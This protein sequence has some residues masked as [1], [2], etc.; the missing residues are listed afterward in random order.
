LLTIERPLKFVGANG[1][2]LK[3][4]WVLLQ[5]GMRGCQQWRVKKLLQV[6]TNRGGWGA[7]RGTGL[8]S[9]NAGF[10]KAILDSEWLKSALRLVPA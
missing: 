9:A 1:I 6:R 5:V 3:S 4:Y 8:G 2:Y 10:G 7:C